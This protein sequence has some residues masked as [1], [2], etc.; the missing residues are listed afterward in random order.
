MWRSVMASPQALLRLVSCKALNVIN[1]ILR[2]AGISSDS[3]VVN[4][5]LL[6]FSKFASNDMAVDCIQLEIQINKEMSLLISGSVFYIHKSFEKLGSK[7]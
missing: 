7:Q 3:L 5:F 4:L 6:L 2:G 1:T